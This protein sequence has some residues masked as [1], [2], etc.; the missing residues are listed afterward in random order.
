[1]LRNGVEA[2]KF[3]QDGIVCIILLYTEKIKLLVYV[4]GRTC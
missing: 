4:H 3:V 2:S 1:M